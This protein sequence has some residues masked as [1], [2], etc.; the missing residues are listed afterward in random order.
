MDIIIKDIPRYHDG[1]VNRA[2]MREL[3]H[4]QRLR[5]AYAEKRDR[6]AAR[7]AKTHKNKTNP[8]LGKCV[9]SVDIADWFDLRKKYG[10]E[11]MSDKGF[12]QDFNKRHPELSPN[13]A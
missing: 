8:I 13:H 7:H 5:Q 4:G 3:L 1:E 2:F 12:I 9:M 11:A 6:R 10:Q